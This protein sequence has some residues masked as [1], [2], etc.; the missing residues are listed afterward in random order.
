MT[1]EPVYGGEEDPLG[2][3]IGRN[4]ESIPQ[5]DDH[6]LVV[7][8][9]WV[10]HKSPDPS[11]SETMLNLQAGI[12]TKLNELTF[13]FEPI[14]LI[15]PDRKTV[16]VIGWGKDEEEQNRARKALEHFS[17]RLDVNVT[18]AVRRMKRRALGVEQ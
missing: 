17:A 15:E 2:L 4:T 16:R 3:L 9:K 11:P 10:F 7:N 5:L 1:K 6:I 12:P 18:F 8:G 13:D 14:S